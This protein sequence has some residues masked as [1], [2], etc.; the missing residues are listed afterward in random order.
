MAEMA[1]TEGD[2]VLDVGVTDSVWRS[3]NFVEALYPWPERITAVG[4]SH[5]PEFT[6]LFPSVTFVEADA[7]ALPFADRTF[8]IGFSNAVIEHVGNRAEQRR[9]VAEIVRTCRRAFIATPNARFP[10]DPHTLLPFVHWLPRTIRHPLLRWS[11]NAKWASEEALNPLDAR[12]LKSLFPAGSRVRIV[13]QRLLGL[14]TVLI[15]ITERT[16]G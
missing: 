11:G 8:E 3:S 13:P 16:D 14:T 9:F 5:M 10:I 2:H 1:P 15:A 12:Q 7:R 4:L 6:R